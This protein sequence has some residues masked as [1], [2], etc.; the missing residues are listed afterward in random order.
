MHTLFILLLWFKLDRIPDNCGGSSYESTWLDPRLP[1]VLAD[2]YFWFPDG[3]SIWTAG[4][5]KAV[6]PSNVSSTIL[7]VA[8][9]NGTKRWRKEEFGPSRL[10]A[11]AATSVFC[12]HRSSVSG[13]RPGLDSTSPAPPVLRHLDSAF[14]MRPA[15]LAL[16]LQAADWGASQLG[17]CVSQFLVLILPLYTSYWLC[18]SGEPW[19]IQ[20]L[21]KNGWIIA[22][23]VVF[24]TCA[25][26]SGV[27]SIYSPLPTFLWSFEP[28]EA[29]GT[30][31]AAPWMRRGLQKSQDSEWHTGTWLWAV[32]HP[33]ACPQPPFSTNSHLL[34]Q[35]TCHYR[36]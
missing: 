33:R 8:G 7:P 36:S 1:R 12:S 5:H 15:L 17:N 27:H 29:K 10:T 24:V 20:F 22:D 2:R 14:T 34:L 19:L 6:R 9:L 23:R 13:A 16:Q 4:P 21:S 28:P 30:V 32:W 26:S 35:S 31:A 11:W 3:I 25:W 18:F